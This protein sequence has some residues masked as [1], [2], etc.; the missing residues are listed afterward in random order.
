MDN[1]QYWKQKIPQELAKRRDNDA[2]ELFSFVCDQ[3][4]MLSSNPAK[5]LVFILRGEPHTLTPVEWYTDKDGNLIIELE[6]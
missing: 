1:P 6:Q 5:R 3:G 2:E 4:H